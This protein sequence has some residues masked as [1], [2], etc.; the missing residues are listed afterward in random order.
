M[1]SS[2]LAKLLPA[3]FQR[4][5]VDKTPLAAALDAM[6]ELHASTEAQL[7]A[8]DEILDPLRAPDR[9][10]PYLARWVDFDVEI[11]TGLARLRAAVAAAAELARWRGC[12]RG[13]L[14]LLEVATGT[15][16]F[17]IDEEVRDARGAPRPFHIRV[18]APAALVAHEEMLQRIIRVEKP[19]YVTHELR[20]SPG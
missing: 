14:G 19:V 17:E 9:F 20:F 11:T 8:L 4:G 6:E 13:L 5:V 15:T 10:V 18:T 16:G 2:A 7:A 12:R 1:K 3:V